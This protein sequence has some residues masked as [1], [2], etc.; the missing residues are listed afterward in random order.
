MTYEFKNKTAAEI[1]DALN[2]IVDNKNS[3]PA[4]IDAAVDALKTASPEARVRAVDD[5]E[6]DLIGKSG[7]SAVYPADDYIPDAFYGNGGLK[8][9][10]AAA[11]AFDRIYALKGDEAQL[12]TMMISESLND[13]MD[14]QSRTSA[15]DVADLIIDTAQACYE[16]VGE[17]DAPVPTSLEGLRALIDDPAYYCPDNSHEAIERLKN[18]DSYTRHRLVD[19]LEKIYIKTGP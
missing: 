9:S 18:T 16:R 19:K 3:T 6:D 1:T 2:A 17:S 15:K 5:F 4:D 14:G 12:G 13:M 8:N 11:Q 7:L 10:L